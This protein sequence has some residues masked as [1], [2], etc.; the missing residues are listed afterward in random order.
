MRKRLAG[1][2]LG[3]VALVALTGCTGSLEQSPPPST[4]TDSSTASPSPSPP[5]TIP[6]RW[7]TF[8][9]PQAGFSVR[10]PRKPIK[11]GAVHNVGGVLVALRIAFIKA[12]PGPIEVG[13]RQLGIR[14]GRK[15]VGAELHTSVDYFATATGSTVTSETPMRFHGK[16]AIDAILQGGPKT[17]EL[18]VFQRD[19]SREMF[20]LAPTG[21]VFD[22][23]SAG[24]KL[25]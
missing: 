5:V 8:S 7:I 19:P 18:L 6:A 14:L 12:S 24:L 22:E 17:L 3:T 4:A 2:L 21:I 9:W 20:V 16:R 1:A 25:I 11:A 10:L 13:D 15:G 23:V